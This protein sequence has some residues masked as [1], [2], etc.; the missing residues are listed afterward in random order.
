MLTQLYTV[1]KLDRTVRATFELPQDPYDEDP[2]EAKL[3][4][5]YLRNLGVFFYRDEEFSDGIIVDQ[6]NGT[7]IL[8]RE[9]F[10]GYKYLVDLD[11]DTFK[12]LEWPDSTSRDA[13]D[14]IRANGDN[15]AW[16]IWE[17]QRRIRKVTEGAV[18]LS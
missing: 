3:A 9:G 16:M 8:D 1:E 10:I 11:P 15:L 5:D 7:E 14:R 18:Y 6:K 13:R 2:E 4:A 12:V 17:Q